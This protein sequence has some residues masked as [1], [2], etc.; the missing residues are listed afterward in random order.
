MSAVDEFRRDVL[1]HL[2]AL[3]ARTIPW[4]DFR[5]S[6]TH[7]LG[8]TPTA[9]DIFDLGGHLKEVFMSHRR[10]RSQ[11]D[12]SRGGASWEILICWYLNLVFW[13]TDAVAIRP[14]AAVVPAV[15]REALSVRVKGVLT[16][17]ETDLLVIAVPSQPAGAVLDRDAID[18][19]IRANPTA[20]ALGVIQC[21]TNWNDNSQIPML[22]NIVYSARNQQ[23][24]N[25]TVGAMGVSPASF[26][27]FSYAFVTVPTNAMKN[28]QE[29]FSASTT[30]VVRVSGLS[31]GNYW[32]NPS[33]TGVA[34]QVS[35]YFGR[36]FASVFSGGVHH[37][38]AT[39][40][41][42]DPAILQ[43]FLDFDF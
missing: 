24:P 41:L 12:L 33:K 16:T 18:R 9:Q 38:L 14:V 36:N 34:D 25:V 19:A 8:T 21:K 30:A 5:R 17:K 31:G 23:V 39:K 37:H 28:G 32:G 27:G 26:G 1:R 42:N 11:G 7:R 35:E 22:W 6:I 10:T 4:D 13:G 3:A 29:P 15:V 2:T 43:M 40:V 20:T